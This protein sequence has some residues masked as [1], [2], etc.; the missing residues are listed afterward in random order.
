MASDIWLRTILIVRKETRCRHIGYSYRL[1]ARVLLYAPSHRQDNTYHSLCNTSRGALAGTRNSDMQ[2]LKAKLTMNIYAG[3]YL[4]LCEFAPVCV[5]TCVTYTYIYLDPF[6]SCW[7]RACTHLA[8]CW[9][10][11]A[12]VWICTC[13]LHLYLPG[14][15]CFMLE[16]GSYSSSGL[17]V[18]TCTCMCLHLCDLYLPGSVCF[19]LEAG[20]YSS[21][22]L[23]V[24]TCTCVNLH[25]YV[26]TPV[27]PTPV[28][29]YTCVTYTC[30]YLDPFV[31]CW[32]RAHTHLAVCWYLLAPVWICTCMCL[33]LCDLH[34]YV[35]TPV[36]PTPVWPIFTWICL[37]HVGGGLVLV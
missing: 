26:F 10:L 29:V 35:F 14:T 28:C 12:P 24:F 9:Y 1:T 3:I 33:H 4:H 6:V 34:L 31:S 30:I 27:W 17:L 37:F 20:S 22:G 19:M 7:R 25:L 11:L 32:R 13:D 15:V 23:L 2:P 36:W 18:F 5:Y 8:V 21:S 16:A